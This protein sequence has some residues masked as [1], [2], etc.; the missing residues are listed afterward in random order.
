MR[1]YKL[2]T[3]MTSY[4][5]TKGN[6]MK[7]IKPIVL[8]PKEHAVNQ[9]LT[10]ILNNTF[11][12][13]S[14]LPGERELAKQIGV[15]RQ[16]LREVLQRLESEGWV[17]IAHGKPT[18]VNDYWQEGG[19]GILSSIAGYA[20]Y[21]PR[22][23]VR[24]LTEYRIFT[25]PVMTEK[26]AAHRPETLLAHL[27]SAEHL[28]D[29]ADAFVK[30]DWRLQWLSARYSGNKIFPLMLNDY[31]DMFHRLG[32]QYFSYPYSREASLQY[33]RDLTDAIRA[34]SDNIREIVETV[35]QN[36]LDIWVKIQ[37]DTENGGNPLND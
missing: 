2:S 7:M 11:P 10:L 8:K 35:M 29:T 20:E 1:N 19:H 37:G 23:F 4:Q 22:D 18:V 26:A 24:D 28:E 5:L 33:Y 3:G 27:D 30:F 14:V 34:E 13:E 12:P 25:T 31:T 32:R 6:I 17:T 16:T 36:S 15:T 9:L 21:L